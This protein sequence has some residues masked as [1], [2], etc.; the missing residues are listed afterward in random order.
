MVDPPRSSAEELEAQR[1]LAIGLFR[2]ERLEEPL[3]DYLEAFDKYREQ[4]ENL[5]GKTGGLS[6]LDSNAL[7]VF[8]DKHLLEAFRY[9]AG[10]PISEDDWKVLA[11][12]PSLA[13]G[14]LRNDPEAVRR[15]IGVV[16]QVLDRRRFTWVLEGRKATE[17]E[18]AAALMASAA[19]MSASRVQTKRRSTGKN[20]Q[21]ARVKKALADAGFKKVRTRDVPTLSLAPLPGEFCGESKFGNRKADSMVRLWDQRVL[22]IECKVSNSSLNSVKRLYNDAAAKAVAWVDDLGRRQVVPS[23]V[24]SGVYNLHNLLDAQER[25]LTIFWA[26]ELKRLIDWIGETNIQ[27][28]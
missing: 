8:M 9:L 28:S 17:S 18:Y 27:S 15:L 23:A 13:K 5:L 21:E 24:L 16:R 12:A 26:H 22:P 10:P 11:E 6:D 14:R 20:L 2:A 25:G 4:V 3:E 19:L 7:E 1:Q